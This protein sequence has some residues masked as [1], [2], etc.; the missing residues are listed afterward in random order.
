MKASGDC[1]GMM[2]DRLSEL[3]GFVR[4]ARDSSDCDVSFVAHK[5]P[6]FDHKLTVSLNNAA[7]HLSSLNEFVPTLRDDIRREDRRMSG[8]TG[9]D[10]SIEQKKAQIEER[11][12]NLGKK[13]VHEAPVSSDLITIS[14]PVDLFDPNVGPKNKFYALPY[15]EDD[16]VFIPKKRVKP[17]RNGNGEYT[18]ACKKD[19]LDVIGFRT[20]S[21]RMVTF[22]ELRMIILRTLDDRRFI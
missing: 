2:L 4:K 7:E 13:E 17:S 6:Y 19:D 10:A 3:D 12:R 14:F 15:G 22:D 1:F 20:L 18:I 5:I 11:V 8:Y 9:N 16:F 21:G